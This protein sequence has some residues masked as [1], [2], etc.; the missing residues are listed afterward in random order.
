MTKSRFL[1]ATRT[2]LLRLLLAAMF[3]AA[4]LPALNMALFSVS[5]SETSQYGAYAVFDPARN[6][7]ALEKRLTTKCNVE[8]PHQVDL[9]L[10]T[11]RKQWGRSR[12]VM[13][14]N[15]VLYLRRRWA[16]LLTNP[17]PK[18]ILQVLDVSGSRIFREFRP[19]VVLNIT[20]TAYPPVDVH[21]MPFSDASFDVIMG[22][23]VFEHLAFPHQAILEMH[24]LL[25][26]G[27]IVIITTVAYNPI[28]M[29]RDFWRLNL[30]GLLALTLQ[31]RNIPLCGAW[32]L[33]DVICARAKFGIGRERQDEQK[34][35]HEQ[36]RRNEPR[37]PFVTWIIAEK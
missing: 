13:Y 21:F 37:N 4:L 28:H 25:R 10:N 24:R 16:S 18:S 8:L 22:D 31:F 12:Y 1:S 5:S 34:Y 27:G 20:K 15:L 2:E 19:G 3:G 9:Q 32:G 7:H 30:Q 23:Q 6:R 29:S 11:T 36:V 35:M 26:P 33:A 14:H 17:S